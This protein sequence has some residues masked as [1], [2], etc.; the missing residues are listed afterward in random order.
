MVQSFKIKTTKPKRYL[1]RPNQGIIMPG[2][3]EKV[4]IVILG[5]EK[6]II[7]DDYAKT[8][9][10]DDSNKFLV[11]STV[12]EDS[13]VDEFKGT[14]PKDH[15][16]MINYLWSDQ[17]KYFKEIKQK[18]L[19]VKFLGGEKAIKMSM[20]NRQQ[21]DRSTLNRFSSAISNLTSS[22]ETST[23]DVK[24]WSEVKD[25]K[26]RY[27]DLV[28]YTV[29]LTAE[30]DSLQH[31]LDTAKENLNREISYKRGLENQL[32]S[33]SAQIKGKAQKNKRDGVGL[34]YVLILAALSFLIGSYFGKKT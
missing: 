7:L 2:E 22:K 23:G 12:V 14:L 6:A 21:P 5:P 20:E 9:V 28:A 33:N 19:R 24:L 16:S 25:L 13:F 26:K 30:R 15:P 1:V 18:K 29:N 34:I 3:S 32:A 17:T 10:W 27:E 8:G 31:N 11:Q 4:M